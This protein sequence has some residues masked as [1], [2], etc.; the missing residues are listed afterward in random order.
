M[1]LAKIYLNFIEY[2]Y[3]KDGLHNYINYDKSFNQEQNAIENLEDS[4]ARGLY[5]LA[6]LATENKIPSTLREKAVNLFTKGKQKIKNNMSSPRA[7][8]FYIEAL[9]KWSIIENNQAIKNEI[10]ANSEHLIS[11]Y[12]DN[13]S[14]G[15]QWFEDI[16]AY[17]NGIIP[18]SLLLAFK[19]TGNQQ[20]FNVAKNALDFLISHSF[21]E[22]IC[23]PIGQKKWFRKG[24]ERTYFDQQPEEVATLVQVLNTMYE[25]TRDEK[26]KI[27]MINAFNWF[28]GN[29]LLG[30]V[31]YDQETGGCYDGVQENNI[32]LNQ[33]AESTIS[34]LIARLTI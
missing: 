7:V 5:A 30:Q 19:I 18:D 6:C 28:L 25:I 20:Y 9:C 32:N 12:K 17:S 11:L 14:P 15:W 33:G 34:Y 1:K 24:S 22:N 27:F 29:N 21:N 16:L 10:N 4:Y 31:V 3:T 26:Y 8:S 2:I 23:I 13:N